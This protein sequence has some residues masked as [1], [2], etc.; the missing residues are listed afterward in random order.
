MA[1]LSFFFLFYF[2]MNRPVV[3]HLSVIS[4]LSCLYKALCNLLRYINEVIVIIVNVGV[5][6]P[7]HV[8]R[9]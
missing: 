3:Y 2:C 4:P 6:P 5:T 7:L 1:H 9:S 8:I